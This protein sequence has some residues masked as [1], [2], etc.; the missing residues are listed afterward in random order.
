[1]VGMKKLLFLLL[2]ASIT[3]AVARPITFEWSPRPADEYVTEYRIEV[4]DTD[5]DAWVT[6]GAALGDAT[7]LLVANF[8]DTVTRV[9]AVAKNA[10]GDGAPTAE[11]IVP[12]DVPG[13]IEDL[14]LKLGS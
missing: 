2:A 7:E 12:A 3:T 5:A 10:I 4:Y 14:R 11:M 1:M 6:A 13:V 8:P 9:R